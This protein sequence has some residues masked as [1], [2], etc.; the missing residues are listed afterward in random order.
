[1]TAG[2]R[3]AQ[4]AADV[5]VVL[6]TDRL[7]TVAR[8][9]ACLRKQTIR[10]RLELVLVSLSGEPIGVG[11][12]EVGCFAR[13]RLVEPGT[14][15]HL[16]AGR[17]A[18]VRA[19]QAPLVYLGESHAFPHPDMLERLLAS[20]T[21]PWTVVV[22]GFGNANPDGPLSW[23]NLIAD[24]GPWLDNLPSGERKRCPPYSTLFARSF[25]LRA[26]EQ[27]EDAFAPGYD[28]V[29]A[30]RAG[31]HRI[32]AQPAARLDHVN[33]SRREQWLRTRFTAGR[34][35]AGV[36]VRSWPWWRRAVYALG[37]PLLPAVLLARSA[38]PFF[39]ARRAHRLPRLTAPA[40]AVGI[41]A[42]AAGELTAFVIGADGKTMKAAD[43]IELHKVEYTRSGA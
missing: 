6:A 17:A 15:M 39:A 40:L 43:D 27:D 7:D 1:M 42:I 13:H 29:H 12:E 28:L 24:Y 20:F 21:P 2:E 34:S 31:G 8:T 5:S 36:R 3:R 14:P 16:A 26:V 19:A 37:A 9:L 4:G 18:G 38:Q 35:Q 30:L 10:D 25:A 11:P 33:V 32:F 41:V 23:S 22:S